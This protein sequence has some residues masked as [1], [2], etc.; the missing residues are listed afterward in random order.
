MAEA[1]ELGRTRS[2]QLVER[3]AA[4]ATDPESQPKLRLTAREVALLASAMSFGV[5]FA[6]SNAASRNADS[7]RAEAFK[8]HTQVAFTAFSR[9]LMS[10]DVSS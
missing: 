3:L 6:A 1:S 10:Y 2:L 4:W 9:L 8:Q 5:Q 7:A